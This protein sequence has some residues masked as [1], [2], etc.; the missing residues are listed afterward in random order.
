MNLIF[1]KLTIQAHRRFSSSS[2]KVPK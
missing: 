1:D 2:R